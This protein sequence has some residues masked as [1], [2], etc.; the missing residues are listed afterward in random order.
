MHIK[1]PTNS[2]TILDIETWLKHECP[3]CQFSYLK[4]NIVIDRR[5]EHLR[6]SPYLIVEDEK[7]SRVKVFIFTGDIH[8]KAWPRFPGLFKFLFSG[9][10]GDSLG[11][12]Q[13][14]VTL[15]NR[16]VNGKATYVGLE[17]HS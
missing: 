11:L 9:P 12:R 4:R 16:Y 10:K 17:S 7:G 1:L 3:D 15:L 8:L 14:L 5:P 2:L 13:R 6:P